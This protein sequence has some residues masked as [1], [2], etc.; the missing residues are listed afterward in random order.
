MTPWINLHRVAF[1][2]SGGFMGL[3]HLYDV[4]AFGFIGKEKA[5]FDKSGWQA[6]P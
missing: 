4:M 5:L 3:L 2:V 6:E 1:I